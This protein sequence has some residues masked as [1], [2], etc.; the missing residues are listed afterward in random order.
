MLLRCFQAAFV[1][2]VGQ[3]EKEWARKRGRKCW[4]A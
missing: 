2:M 3:P 1:C 4:A